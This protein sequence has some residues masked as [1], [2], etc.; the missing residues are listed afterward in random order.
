MW[1]KQ[2]GRRW[3]QLGRLQRWL[4]IGLG[5]L[6]IG[7]F[8]GLAHTP[9]GFYVDEAVGAATIISV[10][11]TGYDLEGKRW[12]LYARAA[13]GGYVTP[14]YLY[15][16]VAWSS[17]FGDSEYAYRAFSVVLTLLAVACIGLILYL[18]FGL[19]TA[20]LGAL[21]GLVIPWS[22]HQGQLA[23]DPAMVPLWVSLA[24]LGWSLLIRRGWQLVFAGMMIAGLLGL[25][26]TYPPSRFAAAGLTGVMGWSLW[27]RFPKQRLVILS[28]AGLLAVLAVPLVLFAMTSEA[29]QRSELLTTWGDGAR[30]FAGVSTIGQAAILTINNIIGLFSP[31]FLFLKGDPNVRHNANTGL[32]GGVGLVVVVMFTFVR[33][34]SVQRPLRASQAIKKQP[35]YLWLLAIIG[36]GISLGI[37]GSALTWESQPHS[38]RAVTAWPCMV[39]LLAWMLHDIRRRQPLAGQLALYLLCGATALFFWRYY[40]GY[41]QSAA[42]WYDTDMNQVL[43]QRA[44]AGSLPDPTVPY[45]PFG[46]QYYVLRARHNHD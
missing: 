36:V 13:G 18:W 19:D 38:L 1:S 22:W 23:W 4:V 3:R 39:L 12:P 11:E 43:T 25:A 24:I 27:R 14:A 28:A 15:G 29:R 33:L 16:G 8:I 40:T 21:I 37:L 31:D 20:L 34:Q 6:V 41:N 32:L 2:V 35:S 9:P 10:R 17:I 42:I 26:Y 44:E 46:Q 45:E 30:S 7:K 5:L